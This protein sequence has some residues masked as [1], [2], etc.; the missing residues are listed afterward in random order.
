MTRNI[1]KFVGS[2]L[3]VLF[4][5]RFGIEVF[6]DGYYLHGIAVIGFALF[7]AMILYFTIEGKRGEE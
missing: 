5:G 3:V 2:F 1:L 4:F 7:G 6:K